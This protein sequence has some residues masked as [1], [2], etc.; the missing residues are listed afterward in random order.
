MARAELEAAITEL[1]LSVESEFVP[2]SKSRNYKKD[3]KKISDKSLNWRVTVR[4]KGRD[5][6]TTDY[7]AGIAHCPS[8]KLV[9]PLGQI[10]LYEAG[11]LEIEVEH[12]V[13][14]RLMGSTNEWTKSNERILPD[15][16]DV[17]HALVSDSDVLDQPDFESW[18]RDFGY[19]T[20]SR[21]AEA[22]YRACV[23]IALKLRAGL[24]EEGLQ[25]LKKA[26]ED[27]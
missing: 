5:I 12:G 20:D 18:A 11:A 6:L 1:G 22:T 25:K 14:A 27:Y 19:D 4:V 23:E 2:W 9:R 26:S 7:G 16:C 17:I 3:A 15:T 24:G 13:N 21:K 10:S 8:Y